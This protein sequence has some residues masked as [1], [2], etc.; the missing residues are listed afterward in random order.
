MAKLVQALLSTIGVDYKQ[1]AI[2][3]NGKVDVYIF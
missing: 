3:K 2:W 1:K